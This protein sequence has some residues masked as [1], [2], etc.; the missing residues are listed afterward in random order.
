MK[1]TKKEITEP[2]PLKDMEVEESLFSDKNFT[3]F[4]RK[5]TRVKPFKEIYNIKLDKL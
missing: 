2:K 5:W 3:P 1:K 4:S